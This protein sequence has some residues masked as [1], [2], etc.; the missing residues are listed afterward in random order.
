MNRLDAL[1]I[2]FTL[3]DQRVIALSEK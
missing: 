1:R 2:L 3:F